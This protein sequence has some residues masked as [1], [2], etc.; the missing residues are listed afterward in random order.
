VLIGE[1]I[2]SV[3]LMRFWKTGARFSAVEWAKKVSAETACHVQVLRLIRTLQATF[4]T[5]GSMT[6]REAYERT[7][8]A[9]N[10]SVIPHDQHSPTKL[11]NHLTA[12]DCVIWSAISKW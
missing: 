11:L 12:P 6:F 5:R 9:L 10:V 1:C 8:R 2:H 4:F 7:G 3:W